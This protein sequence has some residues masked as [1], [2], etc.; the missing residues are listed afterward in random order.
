M[1]INKH[2]PVQVLSVEE[3]LYRDK[4]IH[5]W[6]VL[7]SEIWF[8]PAECWLMLICQ[9]IQHV[10]IDTHGIAP[11]STGNI[12]QPFSAEWTV[13]LALSSIIPHTLPHN[14]IHSDQ[15]IHYDSVD[16]QSTRN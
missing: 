10:Y 6:Q 13:Q 14:V 5:P 8:E 15:G 12:I 16:S 1:F 4:P 11:T 3:F 2:G 7:K 9:T